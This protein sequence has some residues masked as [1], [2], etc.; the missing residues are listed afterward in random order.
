MS[1][2]VNHLPAEERRAVIVQTVIE[3]AAE[4]NP[5]G[6]TTAAIANRMG[7]TQ[8][9]LFR[10]FPNKA[11]VLE[12]V[13]GWVAE[14][15]LARLD[16]SIRKEISP[17][18]ALEAMFMAHAEFV[19]EHPGVPHLLFSELQCPEKAASKAIVQT[20]IQH[21][22]ERLQRLIEEGKTNKELDVNLDTEAAV[23][24]F[25]GMLQGLVMQSLLAGDV[26]H[27]CHDAPRVFAIYQR[28]IRRTL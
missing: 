22:G 2:R 26:S 3:L 17:I 25:I 21:Y 1:N 24:L 28:G 12:T 9:A 19:V 13:M 11:A 27:I 16:N 5:N 14:R 15:L 4:Q 20:L 6:I 7:L 8:G 10:H 18:A 23:I